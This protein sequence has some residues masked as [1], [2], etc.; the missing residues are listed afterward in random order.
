MKTLL[1]MALIATAPVTP[2]PMAATPMTAA[3]TSLESALVEQ[4]VLAEQQAA[5]AAAMPA[6]GPA[7]KVEV[8]FYYAQPPWGSRTASGVTAYEGCVAADASLP[9][10]TVLYIPELSFVKEDGLFVVQDRGSAIKGNRIDVYLSDTA[11][12]ASV[13]RRAIAYGRMRGVTMYPVIPPS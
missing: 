6:L 4:E 3:L 8:S 5:E 2:T 11:G 12:Y 10:G 1:M 9:F 7:A 13:V